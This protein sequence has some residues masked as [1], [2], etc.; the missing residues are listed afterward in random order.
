M[1]LKFIFEQIQTPGKIIINTWSFN[2]NKPNIK[3]FNWH[4]HPEI[5][6]VYIDSGTGIKGVG[7]IFQIIIMEI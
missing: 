6:L 4:Y 2:Q 5:E 1:I 3:N 7:S